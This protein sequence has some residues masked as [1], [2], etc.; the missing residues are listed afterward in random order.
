MV[1]RLLVNTLVVLTAGGLLSGFQPVAG[2]RQ[3]H[4]VV[5]DR[6]TTGGPYAVDDDRCGFPV[7]ID[8][9]S[10]ERFVSYTVPGSSGQAFLE[11][12]W[13]AFRE[14][15]TNP[16]TGRTMEV[17]GRASHREVTAAH[18]AGDRWQLIG[19]EHGQPFVVRDAT[20][21]VVLAD[22]GIMVTR[23]VQDTL[24]DGRPSSEEL[25]HEVVTTF[26]RFPSMADGFDYCALVT[27]L[28]G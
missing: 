18:V 15:I 21:R 19:V 8:G 5:Y 14:T 20:G 16:A 3:A 24:G 7:H 1:R 2:S 12:R 6:G 28:V 11:H 26:G 4:G 17:S 10:R 25:E 13:Y 22:G 23:S 27:R 9:R